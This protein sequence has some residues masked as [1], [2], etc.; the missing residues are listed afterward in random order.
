[1]AVRDNT[2]HDSWFKVAELCPRIHTSLRTYRQQYRQQTWYIVEDPCNNQFFR[3]NTAAFQ[4]LSILD[5]RRTV[6][7]AWSICLEEY[8]DAAPTQGEAISLL[9]QLYSANLLLGDTPA[10]SDLLLK[11]HKKRRQKESTAFMKGI[12]FARIPLYDPND[13]LERWN[14]IVGRMF[15]IPGYILGA[16][17]LV[18]GVVFSLNNFDELMLGASGSLALANLPWLYLV[19]IIIKIV[20][21]CAH[22]FA[23]KYYGLRS[24]GLGEVRTF[25]VAFIF[26][27]PIPY[28]DAS[29]SWALKNKW[30]RISIAAAGMYVELLMAGVAALLWSQTSGGTLV[31]SLCFNVM[32][33]CTMTSLFFNGNPLLKY[34]AYYIL[35]DLL[36]I[37]NF[38]GRSKTIFEVPLP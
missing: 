19:F 2:F 9:G 26:L 37:P 7:E 8:G 13:F 1:V 15:S 5:G 3:I 34:D 31:N 18:F 35:A 14:F 16:I 27:T 23:C 21:E 10:D 29:S 36:E 11:R 4:F 24:G 6:D 32:L 30:Q 12:L 38:E 17:I 20:H 22:G 25:G 28:V 33:T